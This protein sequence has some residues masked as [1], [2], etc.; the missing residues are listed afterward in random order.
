MISRMGLRNSY[1]EL[2]IYG[3]SNLKLWILRFTSQCENDSSLS[4]QGCFF[5]EN[6]EIVVYHRMR[7]GNENGIQYC[8]LDLYVECLKC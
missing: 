1:L 3:P 7:S 2:E 8:F 4:V 5:N 6:R